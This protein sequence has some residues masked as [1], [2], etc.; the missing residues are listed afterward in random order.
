MKEQFTLRLAVPE[1]A[2]QI[3]GIYSRYV[4]ETAVTFEYDVPTVCEFENR[5]RKIS[6]R[7]PWIVCE[8]DGRIV[9]YAYASEYR[10]RAAFRW[11]CELS[12]YVADDFQ[13]CGIGKALY[14]ALFDILRGLGFRTACACITY[15]NEA[16]E[17]A[18]YTPSKFL[19]IH[20]REDLYI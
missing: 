10:E 13:G 9:G 15:P 5:I 11:S 6:E 20:C 1:D 17:S 19:S 12:V 3:I 2:E 4:T 14:L 16:S 7:F 18:T 8:T